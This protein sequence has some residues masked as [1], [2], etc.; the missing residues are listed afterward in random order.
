VAAKYISTCLFG[1]C[2]SNSRSQQLPFCFIMFSV[3]HRFPFCFP[4][5]LLV[6]RCL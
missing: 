3:S 5:V 2:C 1:F 6:G 4:G